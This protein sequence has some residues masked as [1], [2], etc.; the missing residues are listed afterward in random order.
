[1]QNQR[2]SL[3]PIFEFYI[4]TAPKPK[5]RPRFARRGNFVSTYSDPKTKAYEQMLKT[6]LS[7]K[8]D[9]LALPK[10]IPLKVEIVFYMQAPKK[11][12]S[13]YPTNRPDLDNLLKSI[14]DAMNGVIFE[15]DSS[16]VS[17]DA[18]KR[19]SDSEP[20]IELKLFSMFGLKKS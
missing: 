16:I 19:F 17:L 12:T 2:W 9:Q 18:S 8:W 7:E 14:L 11:R 10:D 1:M 6:A 15:D 3:E 20:F 5:G 13:F 4:L